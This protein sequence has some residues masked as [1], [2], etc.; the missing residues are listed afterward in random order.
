MEAKGTSPLDSVIKAI[1]EVER[2]LEEEQCTK[3]DDC[4]GCVVHKL[5]GQGCQDTEKFPEEWEVNH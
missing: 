1:E 4:E 3:Q 5:L 2:E